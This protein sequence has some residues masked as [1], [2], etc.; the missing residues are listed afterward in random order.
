MMAATSAEGLFARF[1]E[2]LEWAGSCHYDLII[3]Q[4]SATLLLDAQ[5]AQK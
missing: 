5:V 2:T 4:S 3:V 1:W